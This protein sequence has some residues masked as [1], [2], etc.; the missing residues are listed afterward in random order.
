[1]R[2]PAARDAAVVGWKVALLS[3]AAASGLPVLPGVVLPLDASAR[4]V[5]AGAEVLPAAGR[6]AA[7][8]AAASIEPDP[9]DLEALTRVVEGDG[10]VVVRSST[11]WDDDGRWSGAFASYLDVSPGDVAAAVRGCWAS[12]FTRDALLRCDAMGVEPSAARVAI[13]V[14]PSI[15]FA[16]GGTAHGAEHAGEVAAVRV[17]VASGGAAGV[18]RGAE[19]S[20]V[21][22]GSEVPGDVE[23][24]APA[25]ML[26]EV[27]AVARA[28]AALSGIRAI[29]WGATGD[30]VVL[31]QIGPDVSASSNVKRRPATASPMPACAR[32]VA[33]LVARFRGPR[34]DELVLRWALG[35]ELPHDLSPI[36]VDDPAAAL[37]EARSLADRLAA[38]AWG[39]PP[40]EARRDAGSAIKALR[41][42]AVGE[43]L[44]A[45]SRMHPPI[46]SEARRLVGLLLGVGDAV[47]SSGAVTAPELVWQLT[48]AE[49]EAAIRGTAPTV[50]GGPDR[51]EGFLADVAFAHGAAIEGDAIV[52]GVGA[53][54]LHVVSGLADIGRPGPRTILAAEAPFPQLAPLL[55]HC[56]GFVARGGS[57]GAHL[58]EVA[59]SLGV[60]AVIGVSPTDLGRSGSLVAVDGTN[61][62]VATLAV[63]GTTARR[64]A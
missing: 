15:A 19:A 14:Q 49:L 28:A 44:G 45:L 18:V 62:L 60:P 52:D 4:A 7:Y 57:A 23:D 38:R 61:G 48:D 47:T 6:A 10:T 37:A 34:A 12:V 43:A 8:L 41:S 26:R 11:T 55:W 3:A 31:L 5:S 25:A 30:R 16:F 17:S 40:D 59:R 39:R 51:W 21:V 22:V 63:A 58:F 54:R 29:E 13:L 64:P 2:D 42:G 56:A 46:A 27:A 35:A 33:S 24:V 36:S 50:R 32:R 9:A 20:T 1:M 53:G